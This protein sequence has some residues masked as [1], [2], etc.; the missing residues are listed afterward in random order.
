MLRTPR[1]PFSWARRKMTPPN[2]PGSAVRTPRL[3]WGAW[4]KG[5]PDTP[6][7]C[8]QP[9]SPSACWGQRQRD[10]Q[11]HNGQRGDRE[12]KQPRRAAWPAR[13]AREQEKKI[14]L[15]SA[16]V[17]L[18]LT[19]TGCI[20]LRQCP[21]H[22]AWVHHVPW[23]HPR[24]PLQLQSGASSLK[25]PD[26]HFGAL[27]GPRGLPVLRTVERDMLGLT[28]SG[29][30]LNQWGMDIAESAQCSGLLGRRWQGT[31]YTLSPRSHAGLSPRCPR[32]PPSPYCTFVAGLLPFRNKH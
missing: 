21:A 9:P 29:A 1:S 14:V 5:R 28:P 2:P 4:N 6:H 23:V 31:L 15:S 3:A 25:D 30:P 17:I 16:A 27:F 13:R 12:D 26:L 24:G 22:V 11:P 10:G 18:E 7:L 20:R 8:P 32:R 19:V